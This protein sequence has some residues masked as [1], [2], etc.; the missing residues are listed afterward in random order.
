MTVYY[1]ASA[2]ASAQAWAAAVDTQQGYPRVGV[3]VGDGRHVKDI[4]GGP[5]VTQ[6]YAA[7]LAHPSQPLWAYPSDTVTAPALVGATALPVPIALDSTWFPP[8]DPI[9]GGAIQPMLSLAKAPVSQTPSTA[10]R[11]ALAGLALAMAGIVSAAALTPSAT[12]T[13]VD[14]GPDIVDAGDGP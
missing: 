8:P 9:T 12:P 5:F 10:R 3:E 4:G 13:A 7:I 2:L 1:V 11:V 6:T 14:A